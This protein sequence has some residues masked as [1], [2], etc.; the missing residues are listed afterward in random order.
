MSAGVKR[1]GRQ[2]LKAGNVDVSTGSSP[3][4]TSNLTYASEDFQKLVELTSYNVSNNKESIVSALKKA[5]NRRGLAS[6][7]K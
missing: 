5:L 2:E 1:K 6:E 7:N 3:Y 4:V